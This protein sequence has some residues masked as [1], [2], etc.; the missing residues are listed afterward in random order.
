MRVNP[1]SDTTAVTRIP[2]RASART[3]RLGQDETSLAAADQL[4]KALAATPAVR[5]EK[6]AEAQRLVRDVS[7]PP[8]ELV[9]KLSVL[10][11]SHLSK[12]DKSE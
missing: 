5:D 1:N 8:E 3:P 6:V 9:E 4:D 11:A 10:L 12:T 7:Y 2:S